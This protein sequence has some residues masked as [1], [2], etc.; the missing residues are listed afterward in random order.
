MIRLPAC[1]P[2]LLLL[3]APLAAQ[4][5]VAPLPWRVETTRPQSVDHELFRGE[6][7]AM[8]PR[9]ESLATP[10]QLP[11]NAR[12]RLLYRSA[13]LPAGH[14]HEIEGSLLD[15]GRV[16]VIW[17]PAADSG[18][19][20]YEYNL[21]VQSNDQ[22]QTL[23]RA[24]GRL[25]MRGT[26]FGEA[27][28]PEIVEGDIYTRGEIHALLQNYISY[29][30]T[31]GALLLPDADTLASANA[32]TRA[33]G[34][35][36]WT[37][38]FTINAQTQLRGD[39]TPPVTSTLVD[40]QRSTWETT[41]GIT[42][43]QLVLNY[44]RGDMDDPVTWTSSD[45]S[46]ATV[47]TTGAVT[48][49]TNGPVH[50]T[51]SVGNFQR[52]IAL[53]MASGVTSQIVQILSGVPGQPH[54]RENV[55]RPIDTALAADANAMENELFSTLDWD[56]HT[57][58]RNPSAW[59]Y[60]ATGGIAPWTALAVW[61]T[62][63]TSTAIGQS[64][65][66]TLI[67]P[68]LIAFAWNN[69]PAV[70]TQ[71]RYLDDQD[72]LHTRTLTARTR[73]GTTNSGIGRLDTP[74]PPTLHPVKL[75]PDTWSQ[76]LSTLGTQGLQL[77]AIVTNRNLQTGVAD[78]YE[79]ASPFVSGVGSQ[80]PLRQPY[81]LNLISGD[82][83]SPAFWVLQGNLI[84]LHTFYTPWGGHRFRPSDIE[85]LAAAL[86]AQPP[87]TADFSTLTNFATPPGP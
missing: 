72:T 79:I 69:A 2:L 58:T 70:G 37:H 8:Q 50:I 34:G 32:F 26:V 4:T 65:R 35:S 29:N 17:S 14:F 10:M 21:I 59:A 51:A 1:L 57:Y 7:I 5:V 60:T 44:L 68:D 46:R 23:A 67:S 15:N 9:F 25:I 36:I 81:S 82:S 84:L 66:G 11:G 63:K 56:T 80:I 18:Q 52:D 41:N 49:I 64:L 20:V 13:N 22:T 78:I 42:D 86:G 48:H 73:I 45:E 24:T 61:R 54:L 16:Q 43:Y 47:D 75:L 77:P 62:G 19:D 3:S 27:A 40:A 76:H 71:F 53:T 6:T 28:T 55:T 39:S 31:N 85:P 87:Q 74:L 38:F 30:P 12:V 83:G 33:T